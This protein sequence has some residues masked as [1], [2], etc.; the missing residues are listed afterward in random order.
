[1]PEIGSVPDRVNGPV[2][3]PKFLKSKYWVSRS[4]PSPCQTFFLMNTTKFLNLTTASTRNRRKHTTMT[5]C[6]LISASWFLV[7]TDPQ[8]TFHSFLTVTIMVT[9]ASS[10]QFLLD[11]SNQPRPHPSSWSNIESY[12]DLQVFL[13]WWEG[14]RKRA[15]ESVYEVLSGVQ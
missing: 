1:M 10:S 9:F 6:S 12:D 5:N 7:L 2:S 13:T 15:Y 14:H 4:T 8:A 11:I 3:P